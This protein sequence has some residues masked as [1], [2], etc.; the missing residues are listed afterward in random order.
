VAPLFLVAGLALLVVGAEVLVRGASRLAAGAGLAPLTVGLTV[1][2][3]GTSAPELLVS[4]TA[5]LADQADVALGNVVGSNVFN[6]LAILGVSALL[7]PLVVAQQLVRFDVPLLIAAS[8]VTLLLALDGRLGAFD[9]LAFLAGLAAYVAF[10]LYTSRRESA[11]VQ[12]EYER[13]YG[14][15]GADARGRGSSLAAVLVGLLMLVAGARAFV[16]GAVAVARLLDVDELVI[17]LTVVAAGTSMPELATSV[18]ASLRGERDIAVGN[19]IGSCLFNVL[20]VLGVAAVVA[21]DGI[22]VAPAVLRFDLPIM[23]I[24]AVA[25]LPVFFTGH[26]IAR[27]E[28]AVFLGYYVAYVLYLILAAADH[29]AVGVLS[30]TMLWFAVPLT[31]LTLGVTTARAL[32]RR[33]A[34]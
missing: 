12:S 8:L 11:A 2:A 27:W 5:A 16:D 19:A 15:P 28:G 32:R 26:E 10:L 3:F 34:A 17:G 14:R 23:I 33:Y 6:V 29:A 30:A 18:V 22:A 4:V 7:A 31:V 20:A 1:V 9:G 13:A 24:V 25:C 21:P